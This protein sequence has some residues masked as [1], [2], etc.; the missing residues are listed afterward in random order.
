MFYL[1]KPIEKIDDDLLGRG[2]F[3]KRT[4]DNINNYNYKDCFTIGLQGE[5]GSGK[6]SLINMIVEKI[7]EEK[8]VTF[9]FNPWNFSSR[10]QLIKDFFNK[11]SEEIF[12]K[13]SDDESIK[14]GKDLKRYSKAIKPFSI[15][16]GMDILVK[17]LS[18]AMEGFGELLDEGE[19]SLSELKD[20]LNEQLKKFPRKILVIID[21][22]DRL[23][24][25]EIREIFQLI[26]S[27]GDFPN[28]IYFLSFDKK[29]V[30]N[31]LDKTQN[32]KGEEYLEKIIQVPI[33]VPEISEYNL[34]NIFMKEIKVILGKNISENQLFKEFILTTDNNCFKNIREVNRYINT[35]KFNFDYVKA[36]L[37]IVDYIGLNLIKVFE[38]D[39]YEFIKNNK[40]FFTNNGIESITEE[41]IKEFEK[42]LENLKK[43]N[44]SKVEKILSFLFPNYKNRSINYSKNSI[45]SWFIER[46][47]RNSDIFNSY[48]SEELPNNKISKIDLKLSI[49][50]PEDAKNVFKKYIEKERIHEFLNNFYIWCGKINKSKIEDYIIL[51]MEVDQQ[52]PKLTNEFN[53]IEVIVNKIMN[54]EKVEKKR[55]DILSR[56]VDSSNINFDILF[57]LAR[58]MLKDILDSPKS[59]EIIFDEIHQVILNMVERLKKYDKKLYSL[60]NILYTWKELDDQDD[61]I[62][63]YI[64]KRIQKSNGLIQFLKDIISIKH[65][66]KGYEQS[67]EKCIYKEN[68]SD[69][70]DEEKIKEK[71]MNFNIEEQTDYKEYIDLFNNRKNFRS[72]N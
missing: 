72:Y 13:E 24:D 38:S 61:E 44:K 27:L 12:F 22:I 20:S 67:I 34:E 48:F 65:V 28:I 58:K 29:I 64:L 43:L 41:I 17:M 69:F 3:A 50:S 59:D 49:T 52:L 51:L 16:P 45:D 14:L 31:S 33:L 9:K 18:G 21:D 35:L 54:L 70:I 1:D 6:T 40:E 8:V 68:I 26:K 39:L 57:G 4:S 47:I 55:V 11:L 53:S 19:K 56:F 32:N 23:N 71:I 7:N 30:T 60:P 63:E 10:K 2:L 42:K 62:E 5:W 46:R 25:D 66:T 15:I 36:E 37:N